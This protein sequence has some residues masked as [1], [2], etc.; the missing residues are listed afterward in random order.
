[1]IVPV[2]DMAAS[3][4]FYTDVLGFTHEVGSVDYGYVLVRRDALMIAMVTAADNQALKAARTNI[5]AQMWL[6]D[7]DGL[8]ADIAPCVDGLPEERAR[9]PFTQSYGTREFHIKDPDGVLL[10]FTQLNIA[11]Q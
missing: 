5:S 11:P 4:S 7:L 8:W 1:M 10:L 6:E 9:A 2:S 3:L